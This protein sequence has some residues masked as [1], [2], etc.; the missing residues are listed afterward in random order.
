MKRILLPLLLATAAAHAVGG[1]SDL[2]EIEPRPLPG[3]AP[4]DP[5]LALVDTLTHQD[6]HN[7][8]S[9][10][11][12]P[13]GKQAYAAAF[14]A[15]T[16]SVLDRQRR[17]GRLK[18]V[19]SLTGPE[20]AGAV[21]FRLSKDGRFGAASCFGASS[22]ILFSREAEN[23]ALKVIDTAGGAGGPMAGLNFCIDNVFSPDG[24][25]LYTIGSGAIVAFE[26]KDGKLVHRM[27]ADEPVRVEAGA[28]PIQTNGRG[29]AISP[30]GTR[31]Y[32]AW[33]GSGSLAVHRRDPESGRLEF[34]EALRDDGDA[35]R[36]LAGVMRVSVDDRGRFVYTAGGRFGGNDA[37]GVFDGG[38]EK[39]V[40]V[41]VLMGEDLPAGFA[42]GNELALSPDGREVA[43]ACTLADTVARFRRDAE[44]G[45]LEPIGCEECPPAANP[46]PSGVGWSPDGR[47]LHVADEKSDSLLSFRHAP[48]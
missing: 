13:D 11:V 38:G 35:I 43:V 28:G 33:Q 23:G 16:V 6:L 25:H 24:R 12:S 7:V 3:I 14:T 22:V 1:K 29:I 9:I 30:D 42:G 40:P 46:G 4:P 34:L 44:T 8:T 26:I 18:L 5:G 27:T 36:G 21:A 32:S 15:A 17:S 2:P 31:V 19:Q 41:Q 10:V 37:V 45:R 20:F 48:R 39:L 47:F